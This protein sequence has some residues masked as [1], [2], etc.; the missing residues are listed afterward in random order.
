MFTKQVTGTGQ[1]WT[2]YWQ[3]C[4]YANNGFT[5]LALGGLSSFQVTFHR[6]QKFY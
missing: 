1:M 4:T 2:L 6:P 5:S 3:T